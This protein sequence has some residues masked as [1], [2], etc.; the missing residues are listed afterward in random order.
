MEGST[1]ESGR[2]TIW[3]DL[4][5]MFGMME[6]NMKGNTRM[7]RSMVLGFTLGLMVDAMKV[8]GIKGNNMELEHI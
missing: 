8:I 5:F 7:I 1:K 6:E 4:A 2:I 3:R